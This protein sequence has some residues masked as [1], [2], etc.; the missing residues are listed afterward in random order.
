MSEP[1][2]STTHMHCCPSPSA[3]AMAAGEVQV[4]DGRASF[5]LDPTGCGIE[6]SAASHRNRSMREPARLLCSMKPLRLGVNWPLQ[7][8][9]SRV[10]FHKHDATPLLTSVHASHFTKN[11]SQSPKPT[12]PALPSPHLPVS[13]PPLLHTVPPLPAP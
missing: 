7:H 10:T 8:D 12:G 13:P 11:K 1:L 3:P 5:G 4:P 6:L 9:S 2:R